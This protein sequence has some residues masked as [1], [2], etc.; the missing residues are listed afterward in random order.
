M[1][2]EIASIHHLAQGAF[3]RLGTIAPVGCIDFFQFANQID[4]FFPGIRATGGSTKVGATTKRPTFVNQTT[5]RLGMQQRAGSSDGSR[6]RFASARLDRRPR[7]KSFTAG[8]M[9]RFPC[10]T[11]LAAL[12]PPDA[13]ALDGNASQPGINRPRG[14]RGSATLDF[15]K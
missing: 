7:G 14:G 11:K 1:K 4:H 15:G 12:R 9:R 13:I 3:E 6:E 10:E 2:C 5:L 8:K